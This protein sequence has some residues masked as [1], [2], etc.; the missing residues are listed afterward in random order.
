MYLIFIDS[1]RILNEI[2]FEM[3]KEKSTKSQEDQINIYLHPV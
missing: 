2:I 3:L 1:F